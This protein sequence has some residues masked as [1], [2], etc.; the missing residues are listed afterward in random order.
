VGQIDLSAEAARKPLIGV[1]L[2]S[3]REYSEVI[4][5]AGTPEGWREALQSSLVENDLRLV[6]RR[7]QIAYENRLEKRMTFIEAV[8]GD[9]LQ[10]KMWDPRSRS[11][12]GS[13]R[14]MFFVFA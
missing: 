8:L 13:P 12:P 2:E 11:Q 1:G 6:E 3:I 10:R 4:R 14:P 5:V 7:V 9:A